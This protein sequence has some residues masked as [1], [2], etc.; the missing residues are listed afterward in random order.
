MSYAVRMGIARRQFG[1]VVMP[2]GLSLKSC[3]LPRWVLQAVD[4]QRFQM[5]TS[6]SSG[7]SNDRSA[8]TMSAGA[9]REI[10]LLV[11]RLK[12]T[13]WRALEIELEREELSVPQWLILSGLAR[14]EGETL[15]HFSRLLDYDAGSL[16]RVIHQLRLRGLILTDRAL[17]DRRNA[18]LQL[19]ETG[20]ALYDAIESR[21]GRLP[22]LLAAT[23][24]DR[25]I[26]LLADLIERAIAVLEEEPVSLQQHPS[27]SH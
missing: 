21:A 10:L 14:K 11:N 5:M 16:S 23:L 25:R 19:S 6:D 22:P 12:K 18:L 8:K 13:L 7:S 4:W 27:A 17:P 3:R 24:G 26:T 20:L 1:V 15:T 9:D 2:S